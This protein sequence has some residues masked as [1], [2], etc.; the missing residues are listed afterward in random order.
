VTLTNLGPGA[1]NSEANDPTGAIQGIDSTGEPQQDIT[2]LF[3]SFPPCPSATLP[4][5]IKAG[6]TIKTCLTFLV[7]G[8]ITKVG[9]T[10]TQN[11]YD[12]PL[13]WSAS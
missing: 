11:Y 4:N 10:G 9:Y 13:T 1:I 2:F 8:G 3:G 6:K 5:P 12:T 7:P